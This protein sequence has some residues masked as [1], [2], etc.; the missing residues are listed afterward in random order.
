MRDS[1][2]HHENGGYVEISS[3]GQRWYSGIAQLDTSRGKM[4]LDCWH[5]HELC[6]HG[7]KEAE[8]CG[9]MLLR[10]LKEAVGL[11]WRERYGGPKADLR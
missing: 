3:G 4:R 5:K 2:T 6:S 1:E 9:K 8:H 7:M 11:G 10:D